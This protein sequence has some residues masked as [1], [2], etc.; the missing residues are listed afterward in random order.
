M[1]GMDKAKLSTWDGKEAQPEDQVLALECGISLELQLGR[2]LVESV[3]HVSGQPALI[4][5]QSAVPLHSLALQQYT[6]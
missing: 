5:C 1:V 2:S 4:H 6:N 3:E